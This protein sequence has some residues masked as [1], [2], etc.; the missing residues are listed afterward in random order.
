MSRH[1]NEHSMQIAETASA[2]WYSNAAHINGDILTEPNGPAIEQPNLA[3]ALE[4]FHTVH[5]SAQL[6]AAE[7]HLTRRHAA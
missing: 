6:L 7:R 1:A 3:R 2:A 5:Y 4:N